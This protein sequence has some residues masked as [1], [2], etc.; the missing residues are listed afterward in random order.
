MSMVMQIIITTNN[1]NNNS[2]KK[3]NNN[4]NADKNCNVGTKNQKKSKL[5]S[6]LNDF[7]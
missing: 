6:V 3:Q 1:N 7:K 2:S 5:V 4:N